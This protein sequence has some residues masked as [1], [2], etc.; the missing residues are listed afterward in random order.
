MS[1]PTSIVIR[2]STFEEDATCVVCGN[3]IAA[4]E[5]LTARYG[6][7]TLRFKC[8]GCLARFE[9]DPERYLDRGPAACCGDLPGAAGPRG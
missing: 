9:A 5:G 2:T 8:P 6:E 7:R 4:G 1:A 3:E